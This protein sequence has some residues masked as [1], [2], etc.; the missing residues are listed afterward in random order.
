MATAAECVVVQARKVV[1]IGDINPD[2]IITPH[3]FVDY[4]VED[5]KI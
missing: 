4:I 1:E 5:E 3:I 2:H